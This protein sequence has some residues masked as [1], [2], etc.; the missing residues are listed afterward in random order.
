MASPGPLKP[1]D[2]TSRYSTRGA[3]AKDAAADT[4]SNAAMA[5]SAWQ[6]RFMASSLAAVDDRLEPRRC[7]R[8]LGDRAGHADGVVDRR[9]D[10]RA[11]RVHPTLARALDA[12]WIERRR[13]VLGQDDLQ[14]RHLAHRRHQIVGEGGGERIAG[15]AVGELLH[16]RAA[17]PLREAA[18]DLTLD[19]RRVDGAADV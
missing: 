4:T 10:R 15:V 16:Q 7:H 1:E 19:Q 13:I 14:R 5:I 12:E 2:T 3:C 17:E 9:R 11:D 18:G 6:I 8:K